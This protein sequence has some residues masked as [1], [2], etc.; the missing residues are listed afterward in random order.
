MSDFKTE[1]LSVGNLFRQE[2]FYRIPAYQRPFSWDDEQFDD[3]IVDTK[4]ADRQTPYFIG[5]IVLH[6]EDDG[7][8]AVVDG[9]QRLTSLLVLLACLRDSISDQKYKTEIQ[10]KIKQDE[11][12]I[13]GIEEQVRLE[14]RERDLFEKIVINDK[15]TLKSYDDKDLTAPQERY[16]KA[17]KVFHER[18]KGLNETQKKELV[19]FITQKCILISLMADSFE[20]AFRLFEI[21][22]DRGKQLRRIDVL[23]S[24]NISPDVIIKETVRNRIAQKWEETE[25]E[26]GEDTFESIFF[27]I[28]LILLKDKP[29]ADLLSEFQNRIFSKGLV[30]KGEPFAKILFDYSSL[31]RDIFIDKDYIASGKP[32]W[33]QYQSLIHIMDKEFRASE[34]RACILFFASKFNRKYFYE[35]CLA[36]EKLFLSQ[37]VQGVRKDERYQDYVSV[38]TTIDNETNPKK[39]VESIKYDKKAIIAA[40]TKENL[41]GAGYAKYALLRLELLASEHDVPKFYSAKSIEHVFPQNPSSG[42]KWLKGITQKD[43]EK[44]VHKIG[45][46][47]LISKSR[48]S[49]SGNFEFEENDL[50]P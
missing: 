44:F 48:N 20:Q 36:I 40:I 27:L 17:A 42:S 8:L 11:R 41:Y 2:R 25:E 37:W 43:V 10:E 5:T 13:D 7:R 24:V 14:V 45:N 19:N 32:N 39:V 30:K 34:W 46:L 6:K 29:Q 18:I 50:S 22:N 31:Y 49:S 3:L 1:S 35:F 4:N 16:V 12:V 47:V 9:Q 23:K 21:V 38:L 15:G 26:V 28:R 33:I